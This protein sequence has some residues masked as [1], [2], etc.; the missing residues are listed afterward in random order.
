LDIIPKLFKHEHFVPGSLVEVGPA[1]V[2]TGG[3]VCNVGNALNRLNIP[4]ILV[5]LIGTDCMGKDIQNLLGSMASN[6]IINP[7]ITTSY[8]IVFD[9]PGFDRMFFHY[10]GGNR[11]FVS[12]HVS[13]ENL[14]AASHLHFG[15]PTLMPAMA[16]NEGEQLVQLFTRAK[17]A[18]L[19]TSLDLTVPD[20]EGELAE[21]DWKVVLKRTLP[22]VDD[23]I[24][25]Q[26][27]LTPIFGSVDPVFCA[28]KSHEFGAERVILKCGRRGLLV[29][30][31]D[32]A[33]WQPSAQTQFVGSTGA[34]DA[35]VAGYLYAK[36]HGYP[37]G[38]CARIA[39]VVAAMC[40]EAADATSGIPTPC[41]LLDRLITAPAAGRAE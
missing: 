5:A 24:P 26:A 27:D 3:A 31:A 1:I 25:S 13:D 22:F 17:Q 36:H 14:H 9:P 12:E 7:E 19:T 39:S 30:D 15:Y 10:P 33:F 23:F 21:V 32:G 35:A 40:C 29:S 34:G 18:G 37:I 6:L 8:S 20:P 41:Q 2:S 28:A 16:A 38:E 4:V 11:F